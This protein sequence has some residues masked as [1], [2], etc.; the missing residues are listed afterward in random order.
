MTSKTILVTFLAAFCGILQAVSSNMTE[1][2]AAEEFSKGETDAVVID[3]SGKIMLNRESSVLAEEF[4]DVWTIN[5][6]A[7]I[8]KQTFIGTS[9]NGAIYKVSG[10][11]REKIYSGK[12]PKKEDAA[13]KEPKNKPDKNGKPVPPQITEPQFSNEHIFA[14]TADA[15]GRLIAAVSGSSCKLIRFSKDFSEYQTVFTPE[16]CSFI[17]ALELDK[18][19][20]IYVAA[21][22]GGKIYKLSPDFKN[23]ELLC[24]LDERNVISLKLSGEN[25]YAGC[26]K[27]G[28]VYKIKTDGSK[29]AAVYDSPNSD[30]TAIET[31]DAGNVYIAAS[32]SDNGQA[33]MR[34]RMRQQMM[35]ARKSAEEDA[36][37]NGDSEGESFSSD[38]GGLRLSI[39]SSKPKK[40][41][42]GGQMP[43]MQQ[44]NAG[45]SAVYKISPDGIASTLLQSEGMFLA[46]SLKAGRLY[47]G[48]SKDGKL[49][50]ID[51]K[52]EFFKSI[53]EDTKSSQITSIT[54]SGKDILV[55]LSN[56][57][58]L[59]RLSEGYAS[60]GFWKSDII[61]AGQPAFWGKLQLDAHIPSGCEIA[62]S[63]RSGN[64]DDAKN[65]YMS[66][67]SKPTVVREATDLNV[68]TARFAQVKLILKGTDSKSPVINAASIA[69]VVPNIAPVIKEIKIDD[70]PRTSGGGAINMNIIAED[71]NND[72]LV[73]TYKISELGSGVWVTIEDKLDKNT[74]Q[75]NTKSVPDGIYK[76][77]VIVSDRN[78]NN[79][80]SALESEKI[81][82][83]VTVDNTP[84]AI[85]E[86]ETAV[87][88]GSVHISLT[89]TDEY[90]RIEKVRYTVDSSDEWISIIPDDMLYDTKRE[91]F[92][93]Q[94]DKLDPGSHIVAVEVKDAG[95]NAGY[96]S[97]VVEIDE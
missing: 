25:L 66:E 55:G 41:E 15:Q 2:S 80:Q 92:S 70:Q 16:D 94:T 95:G 1:F 13:K 47:V 75:W 76:V 93:I 68:P 27:K 49:L 87:K 78:G 5:S 82:E 18:K 79:P 34:E 3:S 73:Y 10:D 81:S 46:A 71:E 7:V 21:G 52:T 89:V 83:K 84:P 19:G 54:R 26:D 43:M 11:K 61:D 64:I 31:D 67:W 39:A 62:V 96:K 60:S 24:T 57:A 37:G 8:G 97:F 51:T 91:I 69:S 40:Q 17:F 33:S 14:M 23:T 22:T 35:E 6:I 65:D 48:T 12:P 50:S 32:G 72:P 42:N 56:P 90:S 85:I 74:L 63:S 44:S 28:I 38:E 30:I 20:N 36:Q 29:T 9:P 45:K 53:Y 77:K 86:S 58:R 59:V 4:D 88:E